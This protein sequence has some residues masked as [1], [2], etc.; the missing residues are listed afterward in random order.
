VPHG[1]RERT[2]SE[3]VGHGCQASCT[4]QRN[5]RSEL[6]ERASTIQLY[7]T[8][9]WS[10]PT[11]HWQDRGGGQTTH[12]EKFDHTALILASQQMKKLTLG[13]AGP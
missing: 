9:Q 1:V 7:M 4:S 3:E 10:P 5:Q 6:M 11:G 12:H 8:E 2:S 13:G